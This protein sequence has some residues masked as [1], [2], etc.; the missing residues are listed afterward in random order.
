MSKTNVLTLRI[1]EELK[2]KISQLA[3]AQGVSINQFAMY[4]LTKGVVAVEHENYIDAYRHG[5][6][7]EEI[8]AA[9]DELMT[10]I[11]ARDDLP[12]WDRMPE[13]M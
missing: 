13:D 7:K 12:E 6:S 3:D 8:F 10:K 9:F 2:F 1:P 11:P 5:H 4:L